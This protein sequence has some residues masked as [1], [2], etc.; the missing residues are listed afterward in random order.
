MES[1][2]RFQKMEMQRHYLMLK[3]SKTLRNTKEYK[4]IIYTHLVQKKWIK[5]LITEENVL[6]LHK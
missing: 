6:Y 1:F 3:N 5:H 4:F 2:V